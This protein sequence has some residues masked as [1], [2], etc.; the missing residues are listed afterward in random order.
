MGQGNSRYTALKKNIISINDAKELCRNKN[1]VF[2]FCIKD[3][4][5]KALR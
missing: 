4:P 3:E 1:K 5:L 2:E